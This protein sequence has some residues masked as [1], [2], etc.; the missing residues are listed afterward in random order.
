MT[1][2]I[3]DSSYPCLL[4]CAD[5]VS[6]FSQSLA[7]VGVTVSSSLLATTAACSGAEVFLPRGR[8]VGLDECLFSRL[9]SLGT[10]RSGRKEVGN[11]GR[12][13]AIARRCTACGGCRRTCDGTA[14][15]GAAHNDGAALVVA[16]RRKDERIPSG[17]PRSRAKLVVLAGEVGGQWSEETVTFLRLLS[18]ALARSES[19]FLRRR[20]QQA[21]RRTCASLL[22]QL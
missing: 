14:R 16:R 1:S 20:P 13:F 17:G 9:G 2:T 10:Q 19:A 22:E 5:V 18:A 11:R 7:L 6:P 12:G 8:G 15:P 21:C 4:C 3:H